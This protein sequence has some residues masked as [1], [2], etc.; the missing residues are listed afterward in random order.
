MLV[1]IASTQMSKLQGFPPKVHG[2]G[3]LLLGNFDVRV[4]AYS[5]WLWLINEVEL[6]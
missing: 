4:L 3:E 2:A 1:E 6:L 5:G